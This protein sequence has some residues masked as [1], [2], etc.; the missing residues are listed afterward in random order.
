MNKHTRKMFR[1]SALAVCFLFL[2]CGL[3]GK[4]KIDRSKALALRTA[5][6]TAPAHD[7]EEPS[8]V[9]APGIVESWGGNIELSP[10]ESGWIA[11]ILVKEGQ[12]VQSGELL[13]VLD[14]GAERASVALAEAEL[15]EAEAILAKTLHGATQEEL[16]QARAE[17]EAGQ[18]R[19]AWAQSN[20]ERTSRL[21]SEQSIAPAEVERASTEAQT[22]SALSRAS[23]ARLEALERGPRSEDRGATRD[24]VV[25]A[26]ARLDLARASVSRRSVVAPAAMTVLLSRFHVGE[27]FNVGQSPL[28]VLGDL[29]KLQV[30]L[31]VDEIDA[32]RVQDGAPCAFYGDDNQKL[33]EGAVLRV[34][35]Q[36][37]R[38][39][40]PIESP[41][42]RADV[43]VRE[44]FVEVQAGTGLVPGQR[45]WGHVGSR[46][47]VSQ[48]LFSK[49]QIQID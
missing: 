26:R 34:A 11:K 15:A 41:T 22:Q 21:G 17:A 1:V 3:H 23:D 25:A 8:R 38:R 31:E 45:V 46:S 2:G 43:R 5:S 37:G 27:F 4:P 7:I 6:I 28:F 40:L 9:V 36:M 29:T 49:R 44:V 48:N 16:R 35:P 10:H 18:A 30:R 33:T 39:G 42:A 12:Q 19:A 47:R 14:D 24:R 20:A 13:A 32:F